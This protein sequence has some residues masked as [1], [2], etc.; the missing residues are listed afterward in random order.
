MLKARAATP[1]AFIGRDKE[2]AVLDGAHV[3]SKG[4][5]ALIMAV[6]PDCSV[7]VIFLPAHDDNVCY[8]SRNRVV[9]KILGGQ[10]FKDLF[11]ER[12][13]DEDFDLLVVAGY[14][15]DSSAARAF[16]ACLGNRMARDAETLERGE[17]LF[18]QYSLRDNRN[19]TD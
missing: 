11:R 3:V 9:G 17:E 15:A 19:Q 12:W 7:R 13:A 8:P 10:Y 2:M 14:L 4:G 16:P 18:S 1:D 5:C 6:R